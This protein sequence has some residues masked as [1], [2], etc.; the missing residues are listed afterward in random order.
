MPLVSFMAGQQMAQRTFRDGNGRT[1]DIWDVRPAMTERRTGRGGPSGTPERRQRDHSRAPLP[2]DLRQGWLAFE[3]RG[4]RCRYTPIPSDWQV[5]TDDELA[6]L[7][8]RATQ[9]RTIRRL[10]E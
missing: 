1:W 2:E 6:A 7:L 5:M 10:I 3:S 9:R 8:E 4:E